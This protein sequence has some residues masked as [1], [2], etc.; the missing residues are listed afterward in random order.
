M[1]PMTKERGPVLLVDD[2]KDL[3]QLIAMR[4]SAAGYT[5]TAVASGEAAL[6][7]LAVSRPHVVVTDLRM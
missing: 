1:R 6:T 3:L 5:V 2:D 7:A 4:L